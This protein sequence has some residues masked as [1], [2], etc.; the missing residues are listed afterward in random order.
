V[1]DVGL[2]LRDRG[3]R[4]G[5][6]EVRRPQPDRVALALQRRDLAGLP[7]QLAQA[8]VGQPVLAL[9]PPRPARDLV[10]RDQT[11]IFHPAQFRVDL[12]VRRMPDVPD[13]A[14]EPAR[15][16]IAGPRARGQHGEQGEA[17]VHG[18]AQAY[19]AGAVLQYLYPDT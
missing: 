19:V 9:G 15:D 11:C 16:V 1:G 2:E 17:Q 12:T 6:L 8:G 18:R 7:A 14:V 3:R 5:E 13:G 4:L 10:G